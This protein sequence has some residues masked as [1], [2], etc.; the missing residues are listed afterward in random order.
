MKTD[1]LIAM[2]ATGAEPV[3]PHV[4]EQRMKRALSVG[5][6]LALLITLG[7]GVRPDLVSALNDP[8]LWV[9][10]AFPGVVGVISLL[11][12][13]RLARPGMRTG[14]LPRVLP[15]PA[16]VMALLAAWALLSA[17]PL[18]NRLLRNE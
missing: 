11:L 13:L 17:S 4:P 1:D 8:M 14:Q 5:L 2:L 6:P 10:F 15:M 3:S 7:F 18:Q 9:K 12:M 16:L